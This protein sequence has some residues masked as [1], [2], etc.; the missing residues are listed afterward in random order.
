M[1][2]PRD[3]RVPPV[4]AAPAAAAPHLGVR[5]A[6]AG[7]PLARW[8]LWAP[9][10]ACLALAAALFLTIRASGAVGLAALAAVAVL[11]LGAVGVALLRRQAA[12]GSGAASG[13]G[14]A[15]PA[16]AEPE[17]QPA[18]WWSQQHISRFFDASPIGIALVDLEGAVV[19]CNRAF[20]TMTGETGDDACRRP[21]VEMIDPHDRTDVT[22]R[23]ANA[24]THTDTLAPLEVRLNVAHETNASLFASRLEQDNGEVTGVMVHLI[25]VTDQKKLEL[26]FAHSQKMQAVGQ[27]AGGIAHDFNNLLTGMLGFC[28]LLLMRHQAGDQSFADIMQIRQN[29]NRAAGLVRQLLAFSRRQTLQPKVLVL[30]DVLAELSNLLRRLISEN[31]EL[32][33]IHGRDLGLVKVDQGQLEQVIINLAVNARDAMTGSGTLTIRTSNVSRDESGQLGHD[34]LPPGDYVLIEVTDTGK[35]IAKEH[36]GKI[37]EPFFSTKESSAGT[38]LGLSTVYGIVKQTGGYIFVNSRLGKGASFRVFLP[39]YFQTEHVALESQPTAKRELPKD[40]TGRG[41]ILLVE[42]EDGVRVFGARA[43]RHKGYSVLEADSGEAALDVIE[44]YDGPIDL[45]ITDVVMP[46]MDGATLAEQLRRGRPDLRVIFISGYAEDA[47]RK[48]LDSPQDMYFLPK[49][50]SLAEL[51]GKV[52]DVLSAPA[53]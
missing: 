27:L 6:A 15:A 19:E 23:L 38:G 36:Q 32:R 45:L 43:L 50:F 16:L 10:A 11:L 26:Q 46:R 14:Q 22:A 49:P 12:A 52:K 47:F 2:A 34:L 42:D 48:R 39:R 5:R 13:R 53:A 18:L 25:D 44:S 17:S 33:M 40:L 29:V 24:V 7:S 3:R 1:R 30:T 35:G 20:R 4:H 21:F 41:T 51:A 8:P 28:D 9:A 31:I 37:F